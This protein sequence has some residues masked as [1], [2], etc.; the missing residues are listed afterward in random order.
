MKT[1]E[2][3]AQALYNHWR[4]SDYELKRQPIFSEAPESLR[5]VFLKQA[6]AVEPIVLAEQA[7]ALYRSAKEARIR[8]DIGKDDVDGVSAWDF[9]NF[10]ADKYYKKSKGDEYADI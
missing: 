4:S 2:R 10:R 1:T 3:I 8:G 5:N 6:E 7:E 9:L